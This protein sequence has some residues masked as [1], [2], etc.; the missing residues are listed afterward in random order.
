MKK[1]KKKGAITLLEIMIV[2]FLIGLIGSVIGVNMKG[3]MDKGRAFKTKQAAQRIHDILLL[4]I[5]EGTETPESATQHPEEVLTASGM[6]KDAQQMVKDG[7]GKRFDFNLDGDDI[8]IYST[9]L[10]NYEKKPDSKQKS[11]KQRPSG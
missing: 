10:D 9:N 4:S 3:S 8:V 11:K 6:V 5:A 1:K 7:W 2:I